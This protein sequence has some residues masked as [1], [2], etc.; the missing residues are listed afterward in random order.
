MVA[1]Y[2]ARSGIDH[3]ILTPPEPITGNLQ[4]A[5]REARYRL[6]GDWREQRGIGWLMTAHHADDQTETLMMRLNRGSGVGGLAGVRARNGAVVRPLLRW[7]RAD[8]TELVELHHLPHV[9]DPSNDDPH[10]DRVAMR[11][12]LAD[13]PWLDPLSVARSASA[14][15]EAEK[16]I[17]WMTDQLAAKYIRQTDDGLIEL[18]H[19]DF[20]DEIVRRLVLRM[21]MLAGSNVPP[22]GATLD[23]AVAQLSA[24]SNAMIGDWLITAGKHWILRRAPPRK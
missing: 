18:I 23:R 3:T 4:S 20:P 1:D 17:I 12:N 21:L 22:R 9:H 16:A 7:R 24:G 6:L 8:L 19:R 5:A 2:C 14:L 11:R 13:A 10:F 15:A